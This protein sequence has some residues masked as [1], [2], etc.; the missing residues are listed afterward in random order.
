MLRLQGSRATYALV[1]KQWLCE[2]RVYPPFPVA[3][4]PP[5]LLPTPVES[6][7]F[8]NEACH[9]SA[10]DRALCALVTLELPSTSYLD[11]WTC[12]LDRQCVF[13][14]TGDYVRPTKDIILKFPY[15]GCYTW[16]K[17]TPLSVYAFFHSQMTIARFSQGFAQDAIEFETVFLDH[18]DAAYEPWFTKLFNWELQ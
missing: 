2:M 11:I 1:S 8:P 6:I 12:S 5:P 17:G 7:E 3:F 10:R 14:N 13:K 16:P 4:P 15:R 9:L 18:S